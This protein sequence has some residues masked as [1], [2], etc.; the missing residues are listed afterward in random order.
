MSSHPKL[1]TPLLPNYPSRGPKII[2]SSIHSSFIHSFIHFFLQFLLNLEIEPVA[3]ISFPDISAVCGELQQGTSQQLQQHGM[4][5]LLLSVPQ[6]MVYAVSVLCR[7]LDP[8]NA[9]SSPQKLADRSSD[10]VTEPSSKWI[11]SLIQLCLL[12]LPLHVAGVIANC[13]H[14][15]RQANGS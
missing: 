6:L 5:I 15:T 4:Y 13:W 2:E 3:G 9:Q 1:S 12:S 14:L 7:L 8:F 10:S 11:Q